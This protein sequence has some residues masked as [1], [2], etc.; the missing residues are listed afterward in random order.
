MKKISLLL[1]LLFILASCWKEE[2]V[3]KI[4][5]KD[6]IVETKSFS[7]FT[8]NTFLEKTGKIASSQEINVS[9]QATG[10]VGALYV[11]EWE[12]VR[13]WDI[14]ARLDDSILNYWLNLEKAKNALSK[15]EIS[16][17]STKSSLDK[18]IADIK[19]NLENLKIDAD[20]SKS[21]FEL[22]KIENSLLK[23]AI[24]YDN[25]KISNE[26]TIKWFYNSLEKDFSIFTTFLDDV[27]DFSDKQLWVTLKNESE[28]DGF[29]DYFGIRDTT[30]KQETERLL[31][32]LL[33]FKDTN[34][35]DTSLDLNSLS[36]LW[37][38]TSKVSKWYKKMDLLLTALQVTFDN[39]VP[40]TGLSA[41]EIATKESTIDGYQT[42][43]NT[44]NASFIV[45]KN[46]ISSFLDTYLNTEASLVKQIELLESDK[47]IFT[48]WLDIQ[49]EL[50]ENTLAEA[51]INRDLTLQSMNAAIV[52]AEIAYRQ[53]VKEYSKLTITSPISGVVWEIFIDLWQEVSN[54]TPL[55]SISNNILNEAT[56]SFNK[57]E[58]SFISEWDLVSLDFE[59]DVFT[60]SI[61][62]ISKSADLNLKYVSRVS[63]REDLDLIGNIISISVTIIAE[64]P[65]IPLNNVKIDSAWVGNVNVLVG[66]KIIQ[67]SITLGTIYGK[68]IEVVSWLDSD[69]LVILNYVDNFDPEKFIIK[70]K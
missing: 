19:I 24:D 2:A 70:N 67:K 26:Q 47:K 53:T 56:I 14:I 43:L 49:V 50:Q 66:D 57:K 45:L 30:Q 65:L 28:N 41:S 25:L 4:E 27:I 9:A 44:Y 11:K 60:G 22:E 59:W 7:G 55:F 23:L 8:M 36:D 64:Y 61:Y 38:Y 21:S 18:Q 54:G 12:S 31:R 16:Y 39:S 6:F 1:V 48:K 63:F 69:D 40:S 32:E 62:S 42:S 3:E 13:K 51:I 33:I 58:L 17:E 10:R 37:D 20:S 29:E 68:S 35:I 34:K 5:K 15:T 52:D 46:S